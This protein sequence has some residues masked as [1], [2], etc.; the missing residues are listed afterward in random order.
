MTNKLR[1]D[2]KCKRKGCENRTSEGRYCSNE[3]K[4][5]DFQDILE[6]RSNRR[7]AKLRNTKEYGVS[8]VKKYADGRFWATSHSGCFRCSFG[9]GEGNFNKAESEKHVR[10]KFE[11][12]LRHKQM[13]REV[14]CEL[15]LKEGFGRPDLVVVDKGYVFVEEIVCSEKEASI[16]QKRSKYPWPIQ[17]IKV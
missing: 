3:C 11:R 14:F 1:K 17:V 8:E 10:A 13:G 15:R 2:W 16:V 5:L 9:R 4:E 6:K 7:L 12:W